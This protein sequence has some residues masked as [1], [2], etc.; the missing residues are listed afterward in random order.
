MRT[1]PLK[2]SWADIKYTLNI[3]LQES[4]MFRYGSWAALELIKL[5]KSDV[6]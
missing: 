3:V 6:F 4:E 5:L 2:L 1:T